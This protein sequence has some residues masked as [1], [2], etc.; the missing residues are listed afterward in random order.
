MTVRCPNGCESA[1]TDYCDQCGAPIGPEHAV[2]DVD[3]QLDS[4]AVTTDA[5]VD[6]S[7]GERCPRCQ[8]PRSGTDRFCE[9]DGYDF[10]AGAAA[11]VA[12]WQAVVT[13]D[14]AYFDSLD[15]DG[16]EF[17]ADLAPRTIP[18]EGDEVLIGRRSRS[19]GLEP[20]IDLAGPP[21]DDAV[22]HRHAA[23]VRGADGVYSLVD[24]GST[25]GTTL[26][27][28]TEPIPRDTPVA[29]HDGSRIHVGA[30]TTIV[31]HAVD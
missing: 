30:W 31:I 24:R 8:T 27:G 10:V 5:I 16:A 4:Q 2:A 3:E 6:R 20:G 26:D 23:L 15:S 17:P 19:R 12:R 1:T 21:S 9:V 7:T 18:L 11:V 13:A 22:S 28:S 14:R 25:N 29:L